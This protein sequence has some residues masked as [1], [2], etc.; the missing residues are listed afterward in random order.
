MKILYVEDDLAVASVAKF[1]F[2]KTDYQ[3]VFCQTIAAAMSTLTMCGQKIDVILL[4]LYLPDGKGVDLL[5]RMQEL[6]LTAHVIVTTGY[7]NDHVRELKP[8]EESGT[9]CKVIHKPFQA[10]EL[11]NTL[12]DIEKSLV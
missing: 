2:L 9:V 8:F 1:L 12:I 7:Y 3:I 4:D 10:V 6:N 11:L 5:K